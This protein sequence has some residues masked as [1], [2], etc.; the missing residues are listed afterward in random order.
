MD[1]SKCL[2][3]MFCPS[4]KGA[5]SAAIMYTNVETA[6]SNGADVSF[7]LKYLLQKAPSTPALK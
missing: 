7:Y 2:Y 3:R 6:K 4:P 1:A 5:A